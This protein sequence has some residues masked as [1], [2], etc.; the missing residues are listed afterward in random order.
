MKVGAGNNQLTEEYSYDPLTGLM[1][2]QKVK[3][4][5]GSPLLE[6]S[7]G[8]QRRDGNGNLIAGKTGHL[9]E[10]VNGQIQQKPAL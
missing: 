6:L 2:N 4:A 8:Y 1:T 3:T 9:T 7:Y 5:G 10:I